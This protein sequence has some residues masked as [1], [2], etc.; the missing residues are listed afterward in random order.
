MRYKLMD[1]VAKKAYPIVQCCRVLSVSRAGY[2]QYHK[3][4]T[5]AVD[6]TEMVQVKTAFAASGRTYGSRRNTML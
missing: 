4:A 3:R 5:A 2:Y 6:I 1:M